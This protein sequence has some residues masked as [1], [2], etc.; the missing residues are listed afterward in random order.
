M[1][2]PGCTTPPRPPTGRYCSE[3]LSAEDPSISVPDASRVLETGEPDGSPASRAVELRFVRH[4]AFP[5]TED[6]VCNL[7]RR[8]FSGMAE[9]EPGCMRRDAAYREDHPIP[10]SLQTYPEASMGSLIR[11]FNLAPYHP[12][13]SASLFW[14]GLEMLQ[15]FSGENGRFYMD[16]M[17][18]ALVLRGHN[19]APLCSIAG[20]LRDDGRHIEDARGIFLDT[21]NPNPMVRA[22]VDSMLNAYEGALA[23]LKPLDAK[24]SV[25]GISRSILRHSRRVESF[26]VSDAIGWM[27]DIS[28]QTFRTRIGHLIDMGMLRKQGRTKGVRYS[29]IDPL[30]AVWKGFG[31]GSPYLADDELRVT[32]MGGNVAECGSFPIVRPRLYDSGIL[33]GYD[34]IANPGL[35]TG[36]GLLLLMKRNIKDSW[37]IHPMH[38]EG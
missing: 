22:T 15:P 29:Y 13:V 16:V 36:S 26:T 31:G 32:R 19:G 4:P 34:L 18:T 9:H 28:D 23:V 10:G 35:M 27:D 8:A 12:V 7:H 6:T 37:I 11:M 1:R 14:N 38:E 25:D 2:P 30:E 21:G 3:L 5:W 24:S 17:V 20:R 33:L